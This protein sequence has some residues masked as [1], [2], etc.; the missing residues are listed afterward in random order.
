MQVSEHLRRLPVGTEFALLH[1]AARRSFVIC[2]RQLAERVTGRDATPISDRAAAELSE[3]GLLVEADP[4]AGH[5]P[6][7]PRKLVVRLDAVEGDP[8][9][10]GSTLESVAQWVSRTAGIEGHVVLSMRQAH[11]A[12][13]TV[14]RVRDRLEFSVTVP[15]D[16]AAAVD[17]DTRVRLQAMNVGLIL[18]AP[19]RARAEHLADW[20][21]EW[22]PVE[23]HAPVILGISVADADQLDAYV[24]ALSPVLKEQGWAI[25]VRLAR[26]L[27]HGALDRTGLTDLLASVEAAKARLA[28]MAEWDVPAERLRSACDPMVPEFLSVR[29]A[30]LGAALDNILTALGEVGPEASGS[31]APPCSGCPIEGFC[32]GCLLDDDGACPDALRCLAA[33]MVERQ[34][35]NWMGTA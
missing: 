6:E 17:V 33:T 4:G 7:G 1:H 10:I 20:L 25:N 30:T 5:H 29:P 27:R 21:Q 22:A 14:S 12:K 24:E 19:E 35:L 23:G 28:L 26:A 32:R 3:A 31:G 18:T 16:S 9:A 15:V 8:A 13:R 34:C 2:S 11:D